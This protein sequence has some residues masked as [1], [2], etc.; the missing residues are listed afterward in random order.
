MMG[1][2][3][4]AT[5]PDRSDAA[6]RDGEGFGPPPEVAGR[7]A[8]KARAFARLFGGE[9]DDPPSDVATLG[10]GAAA[11]PT[12]PSAIGRF[13]VLERLGGGGMG[14]VYSAWDPELER[15]VAIK[16]LRPEL[17]GDG[18][19][20]GPAR[21]Q[22]EAQAMARIS[23]PHVIAVHEVGTFETQVFV[24]MEL[25]EG[26]TLGEWLAAQRRGWREILDRFLDA[27]SGIAAA[28]GA[29][30]VHRD[31]KPDN[32]LVGN[33]GRVRVLDF[34]LARAGGAASRVAVPVPIAFTSGADPL[35]TP[36]T[37]TGAVLGTPAYM[38]PEQWMGQPADARSDQ[39]SFC[40]ALFEAL[41]RRRPFVA[42][43]M[44]ELAT[45]VVAGDVGAPPSDARVP[46]FVE[47][48]LRRGLARA[49][50]QR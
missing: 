14:V 28:H 13:R 4:V 44:Q 12:Q 49:P 7:D 47:L 31:F 15:K 21:L 33:D 45:A 42:S 32:V 36:L 16:L 30:V 50:E 37:R 17:L 23:D 18:S 1:G 5:P 24:A 6:R 3:M 25:V 10:A 22:R 34:G 39:F 38:S 26:L 2:D 43:T 46:R 9:T 35:G 48:A 11:D 29:G 19:S 40:V 20:I 27:G 8:I 41:Y